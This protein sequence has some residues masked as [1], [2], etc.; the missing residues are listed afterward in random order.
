[1]RVDKVTPSAVRP[2]ADVHDLAFAAWQQDQRVQRIDKIAK[3]IVDAVN[4]GTPLKQVA[5]QRKLTV[6]TTPQLDRSR[7]TGGLPGSVLTAVFKAKPHQAA[8]GDLPEGVYVA[9]LT[10]VIAADPAAAKSDVDRL[11]T[12]LGQQIQA[13]L[14][15]EYTRAL[16]RHFPV[17]IDQ[18]RVDR[19]L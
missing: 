18:A 11:T 6:T 4:A 2:L 9:E 16:R 12:Q 3:D 19:A 7:E 5:E 1:M 14:L 17:E 8:Q 13:D 15:A 10:E